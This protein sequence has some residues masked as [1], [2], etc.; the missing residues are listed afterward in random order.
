MCPQWQRSV[1]SKMMAA[2]LEF[3][4]TASNWSLDGAVAMSASPCVNPQDQP[5]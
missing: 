1:R 3:L 5:E 4:V 2:Y